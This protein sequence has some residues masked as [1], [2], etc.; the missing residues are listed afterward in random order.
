M[1]YSHDGTNTTSDSFSYSVA[2]PTGNTLAAQ[3]FSITVTAVD[4]DAPTA[5]NQS[6]T[7][8]EGTT[9]VVLSTTDL[10][11]TDVDTADT[12]LIYTVGNVTNGNLT[13][14]GSAWAAGTNDTFTQQDIIDGNV[15]YS[16]D[17]TNTTSDSF[18]Y[19]VADPAGNTL[20]A[21][22]FSITVTAVNDA[23][24]TTPVTLFAIAEDSG[25][26]IITQA[27]LLANAN[28]VDGDPLTAINLA[29]SAGAGSLVDNGDGTWNYTPALNDDTSVSFS[30][31][32]TDGALTAAGTAT[33]DITP[34]NDAP[35]TS[36]V[37]LTSIAE[38]SGVRVITQAELLANA[39]D[40]D[41]DALTATSLTISAGLGTLVDNGDG[42]WNYT[43][44]LND[45]TSVSFSYTI[46]DG[47][48]PIAGSASLDI[49]PVNDVPTTSAV[50]LT[51]IS[52]DSDTPP[53]IIYFNQL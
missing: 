12:T 53:K 18:S 15:L 10:S 6:T 4:D 9:N 34:L 19:S 11:S 50:T 21:Q 51:A 8:S 13:I 48:A 25:I 23:P 2:D 45:D 49:T 5:V 26:R 17:G 24:T 47:T 36:P 32:V 27:E 31:T 38:D 40:V 30:Y 46:T 35:T 33:L 14:N 20:A 42:T 39:G 37:T 28:D 16:H 7:V 44:V 52:E 22:T 41:G 43:P 3:T 1:L 29:I